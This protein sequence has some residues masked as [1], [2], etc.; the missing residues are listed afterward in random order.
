MRN[1]RSI[2]DLYKKV[3]PALKSKESSLSLQGYVSLTCDDIWNY[4]L[5]TKWLHID[6]VELSDIIDDIM[7]VDGHKIYMLMDKK[8]N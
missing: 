5:Q 4:L 7:M 8:Y 1:I 2:E 3:L 6:K